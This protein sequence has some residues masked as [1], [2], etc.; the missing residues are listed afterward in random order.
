LTKSIFFVKTSYLN[1]GGFEMPEKLV[2]QTAIVTG[3]S[4]GIGRAIAEVLGSEGAHIFLVGRT[5]EAMEASKAKIERL[6]GRATIAAFDVREVAKLQ[7][8]IA[9][10][11]QQTGRLDILVNNAGVQFPAP[12][13]EA[14]FEDWRTMLET[15]VLALLA[16]TQAAIR[17][18]RSLN[19]PGH[20]VNI[21][22]I[23][24]QNRESGVYG[25]TKHM[26]NVISATLR[27]ELENDPIRV[28]TIMPGAIATNF[29]RNY[30]PEFLKRFVGELPFEIQRGQRLPDEVLTQVQQKLKQ[31]LCS[32]EDIARTVLWALTQ[33]IDVNIAEIVVRPP[34][35]INF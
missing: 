11:Q 34:R 19:H 22:S 24:S 20:I 14:N 7:D 18:M 31:V 5:I 1:R 30:D 29:A 10:V 8:F 13:A 6:G 26:V 23:A 4:S 25:G 27:K 3:A 15:N 32:P 21:S 17:A 16:G 28:T 2:N 12:I 9:R 33:P 35:A